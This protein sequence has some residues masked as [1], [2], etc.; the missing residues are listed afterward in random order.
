[1]ISREVLIGGSVV[2][3]ALLAAGG[4]ALASSK[5]AAAAAATPPSSF[6]FAAGQRYTI[7][8]HVPAG[9]PAQSPSTSTAQSA[10]D[11]LASGAFRVASAGVS[12]PLGSTLGGAVTVFFVVDC[13]SATTLTPAGLLEG[14]PSGTTVTVAPEGATPV[15]STATSGSTGSSAGA[16]NTGGPAPTSVVGQPG[17]NAWQTVA[18]LGPGS[19][20]VS[21]AAGDLVSFQLPPGATWS[22]QTGSVLQLFSGT[23]PS[24]G[25]GPFVFQAGGVSALFSLAWSLGGVAYTTAVSLVPGAS[26]VPATSWGPNDQVRI[27]LTQAQM[28]TMAANIQADAA[29]LAAL[30][31]DRTALIAASVPVDTLT[32]AQAFGY[33]LQAPNAP[34]TATLAVDAATLKTFG[35]GDTL[36]ADWPTADAAGVVRAAFTY[37][38]AGVSVAA[39]PF[40]LTAWVRST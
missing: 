21:Q 12:V 31:A 33:F 39:L 8:F 37:R 36:P 24:S 35:T 23:V 19:V 3:A 4:V 29:E 28:Q 14:T 40:P 17:A 38:G 34:W 10:L 5:P 30:A 16:G 9:A 1:M 18:T 2:V 27:S 22:T 7:S 13:A 6:S 15:G 26:Y 11:A 32:A 20:T 25:S